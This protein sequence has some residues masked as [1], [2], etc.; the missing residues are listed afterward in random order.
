MKYYI[1]CILCKEPFTESNV[2]TDLG[3]KETQVS[4][5]CEKCFDECFM[6]NEDD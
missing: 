2:Y 4:G 1:K 3:W 6:D 5:M